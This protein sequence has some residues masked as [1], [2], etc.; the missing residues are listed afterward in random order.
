MATV[1]PL[2]RSPSPVLASTGARSKVRSPQ[3]Q[4]PVTGSSGASQ[5]PASDEVMREAADVQLTQLIDDMSYPS[6][7]SLGSGQDRASTLSRGSLVYYT[8][9]RQA[10]EQSPESGPLLTRRSAESEPLLAQVNYF[11]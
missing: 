1:S 6:D 5:T 2:R 3:N 7:L 4:P 8:L 9:P 10:A 11:A